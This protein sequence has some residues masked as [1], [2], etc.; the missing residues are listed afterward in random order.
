MDTAGGWLGLGCGGGG[1]E[2]SQGP[3]PMPR[4]A[5]ANP[6]P[7]GTHHR[8]N[9]N[10][11][12]GAHVVM[13]HAPS[14]TSARKQ[15]TRKERAPERR[16]VLGYSHAEARAQRV[17]W[18]RGTAHKGFKGGRTRRRSTINISLTVS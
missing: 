9:C 2:V 11:L 5:A 7:L 15:T 12:S 3:T 6:L 8:W 16:V 18:F 13:T 17:K 10:C 14:G 4:C 1:V